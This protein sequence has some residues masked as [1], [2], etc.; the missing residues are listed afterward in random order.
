MANALV[1]PAGFNA[2]STEF[3]DV[4]LP[5]MKE[6]IRSGYAVIG[7]R[8]K[9]WS[10]KFRGVEMPL[11]RKDPDGSEFPRPTIELVVVK[12]SDVMSKVY[13]KN[14]FK[15]GSS[16]A[17]TCFSTNG[18]TPDASVT[19]EGKQSD[20]CQSCKQNVFGSR[21]TENKRKAKACADSKRLAV[22]PAADMLNEDYGG[23]MLLRIPAASL[24]VLASF[25]TDMKR[26]GF[27]YYSFVMRVGFDPKESYPKF[28]FSPVRPLDNNEAIL[29]KGMQLSEQVSNV[30]AEGSEKEPGG[31]IA[32]EVNT[33]SPL[34]QALTSPVAAAPVGAAGVVAPPVISTP[35]VGGASVP[36]TNITG[37]VSTPPAQTAAKTP[38]PQPISQITP[39]TSAPV[40]TTGN[41]LAHGAVNNVMAVSAELEAQLDAE[42]DA[43]LRD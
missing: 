40:S 27:P 11:M 24:S 43:L 18:Y 23:P 22:T 42:L 29:I 20:R 6:G 39:S 30:L 25:E 12:S 34:S 32:W 9:T 41:G 2:P 8:G 31:G 4:H 19:P 10:I 15:E 21:I 28:T 17:P 26:C 33:Q 1:L 13:Y 14:G 7:Y 16:D 38:S 36:P 3:A 5:D 35:P 37:P